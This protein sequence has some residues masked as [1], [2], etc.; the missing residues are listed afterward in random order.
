MPFQF[1]NLFTKLNTLKL[2]GNNAC[3]VETKEV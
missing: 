3:D 2:Q 1:S